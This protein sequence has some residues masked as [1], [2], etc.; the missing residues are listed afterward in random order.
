MTILGTDGSSRTGGP[1]VP[2]PEDTQKN[3]ATLTANQQLLIGD[4]MNNPIAL[5]LMINTDD[6]KR[7]HFQSQSNSPSLSAPRTHTRVDISP[8]A[9]P[10]ESWMQ[11][12]QQLIQ[13]LPDDAKGRLLAENDRPFDQ[14]SFLYT[15]LDNLLRLA[16]KVL[17]TLD[18]ISQ[19]IA[20]GSAAADRYNL[21]T[22]LPYIGMVGASQNGQEMVNNLNNLL[23]TVGPNNPNYDALTAALNQFVALLQPFTTITDKATTGQASTQDTVQI[24][25]L[26]SQLNAT[27]SAM[28][29]SDV[30]GSS[31]LFLPYLSTLSLVANAFSDP[32]GTPPS[33]QFSLGTAFIGL[34]GSTDGSAMVGNEQGKLIAQTSTNNNAANN[35]WTAILLAV[36]ILS[37]YLSTNGLGSTPVKAEKEVE[38]SRFFDF[39]IALHTVLST[40]LVDTLIQSITDTAKTVEALKAQQTAVATLNMIF[41]AVLVGSQGNVDK[42][43]ALLSTLEKFIGPPLQTVVAGS[44]DA[45]G[46]VTQDDQ[47]IA[48]AVL[49]QQALIAFEEGQFRQ[50]AQ[51]GQST[52]EANGVNAQTLEEELSAFN[53]TSN[54]LAEGVQ[55][56]SKDTRASTTMEVS[57]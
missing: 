37:N 20:P 33:L 42:Q 48:K 23:G 6:T 35:V 13:T 50:L 28:Q 9:P 8:D 12:Y 21:Y 52:I 22:L 7:G 3:S 26:S 36:S 24:A 15:G 54:R 46:N 25:A 18:T 34:Q 51:V 14:R 40:K 27:T 31:T 1:Q 2:L 39:Q 4:T 41:A 57:A 38:A 45:A 44:E 47:A 53:L 49:L 56:G 11:R 10:D 17:V 29:Q 43:S 30:G 16:A 32:L 55:G 19:P 5:A